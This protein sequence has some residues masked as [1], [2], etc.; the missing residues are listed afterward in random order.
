M[1]ALPAVA[2][3]AG[4]G[5]RQKTLDLAREL[6]RRGFAGIYCAS[7]GDGVGLC[8]ALND[9][10]AAPAIDVLRQCPERTIW[11]LA[12]VCQ[13]NSTEQREFV[14]STQRLKEFFVSG[15][16]EQTKDCDAE[17]DRLS[18]GSLCRK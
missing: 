13:S 5:R 3:A 18:V 12:G 8:E 14:V 7:F 4:P 1:P 10:N 6:E 15:L 16:S 11:T 17:L 9:V 2:L